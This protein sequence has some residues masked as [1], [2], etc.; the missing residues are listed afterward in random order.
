M[1]VGM[2]FGTTNSAVGVVE[3]AGTA[4]IVPMT[5]AR[6]HESATLRSM[7]AFDQAVKDDQR[8]PLARIGQDA[9]DAYLDGDG[10]TR[11]LQSFKS[12]LTSRTF[13]NASIF[14]ATFALEDLIALVVRR[15]SATAQ[16]GRDAPPVRVVAGRPVRFVAEDGRGEESFALG[17]LADAFARAGLGEVGFEYEP[18]AA[19]YYYERQ[20][21]RDETVLVAD[22]GGGTSDF[23]LVRLGPGRAKL[24]RPESA[25]LGTAGVGNAGDALDRRIVEQ[26]IAPFFGRGGSYRS[27]AKIL[28]IPAWIY[29]RFARWHHIGFLGTPSTLRMLREIERTADHP[30]TIDRLVTLIEHNLGYHLY[31]A[32]EAVKIAL[33][34]AEETRFVFRHPPLVLEQTITR[35]DFEGWIAPEL[36]E[37]AACVD[38]LLATTAT[39][40]SAVDRVFMT[41]G[42]SLVP[43][44]RAIFAERFGA[45]KLITGGEFVSV[46]TGLAYR[47]QALGAP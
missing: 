31:R 23:C 26:A 2:D 27:D 45:Q 36:A 9:I 16:A 4:R 42:T 34:S 44:V 28:P 12:Y 22:F 43:A 3:D 30:E 11:L 17:R 15:L 13:T 10:E 37:I 33:S 6:G 25:I 19:A 40:A 8:R 47:A 41:G 46:A 14:N 18:I 21:T 32:V 39:P 7:L 35:Q 29:G 20:L 24:N 5:S 38:G 1:F